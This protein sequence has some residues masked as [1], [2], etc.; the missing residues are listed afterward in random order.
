[1]VNDTH[2]N[3]RYRTA[4]HQDHPIESKVCGIEPTTLDS[5]HRWGRTPP[6]IGRIWHFK[7][8]DF[9]AKTIFSK[10]EKA[11]QRRHLG[12]KTWFDFYL[13]WF[14]GT[15]FT[16][17]DDQLNNFSENRFRLSSIATVSLLCRFW[18][19]SK[20]CVEIHFNLILGELRSAQNYASFFSDYPGRRP[21]FSRVPCGLWHRPR[22]S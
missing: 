5:G 3:S 7:S 12:F 6:L 9:L 16:Q 8:D 15:R 2:W 17:Q 21:D 10:N 4:S 14:S 20:R 22:Q 19:I 18:P 1:M 13:S 11:R